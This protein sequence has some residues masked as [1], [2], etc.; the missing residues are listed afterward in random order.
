MD[1][2]EEITE[3]WDTMR[4]TIASRVDLFGNT[5]DPCTRR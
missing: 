4:W 2:T 3:R 5:A 1:R